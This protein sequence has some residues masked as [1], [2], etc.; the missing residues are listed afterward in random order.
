[1][2]WGRG[3]HRL[4]GVLTILWLA[5]VI[6]VVVDLYDNLVLSFGKEGAITRAA[7]WAILP[8]LVIYA[9]GSLISWIG[10]GFRQ[11]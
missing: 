10:R 3:L 1:M 2:N 5:A 4:W 9:L 6:A 7:A 11:E 8:P